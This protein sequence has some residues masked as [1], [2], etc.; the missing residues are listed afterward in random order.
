MT[1]YINWMLQRMTGEAP[2]V[3]P[4]LT[5]MTPL[6]TLGTKVAPPADPLAPAAPQQVLTG[7]RS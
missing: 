3:T 4:L 7:V 1:D 6:Q 2:V 5:P